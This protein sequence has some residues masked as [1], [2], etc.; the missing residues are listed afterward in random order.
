MYLEEIV[1]DIPVNSGLIECRTV[2]SRNHVVSWLK[3]IAGF[4][5]A[6]GGDLYIGVEGGTNRIIGLDREKADAE[7]R[8]LLDQVKHHLSP[9]PE[10]K[11]S[12]F[13]HGI[14]N[15]RIYIIRVRVQESPVK[16]VILTCH[17]V[18]MIFMHRDG[19]TGGATYDEIDAMCIRSHNTPFDVL[20]SDVKYDPSRFSRLRAFYEENNRSRSLSENDLQAMGFYDA[21]GYLANGALLFADNYK[22]DRTEVLCTIHHSFHRR[23]NDSHAKTRRFTKDVVS[24][25]QGVTT[26]LSQRMN[27]STM[28]FI[29][30]RA[31]LEG[32]ALAVAQRDYFL[33]GSPILVDRFPDRLEITSPGGFY[34]ADQYGE[35]HDLT[36]IVSKKRNELITAVLASCNVMDASG[37]GFVETARKYDAADEKHKPYLRSYSDHFTLVLPDLTYRRGLEDD[38]IPR[39][40]ALPAK[41]GTFRDNAV[42]SFC[43]YR[44]RRVSE[45]ADFLKLRDSH[46]L[47]RSILHN[48][49]KQGYLDK[50]RVSGS[51][52]YKTRREMV[53]VF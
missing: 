17:D 44:A 35:T 52:Y 9:M 12:F 21:D 27:F 11:L 50:D 1:T 15:K 6:G 49:V 30:Q 46:Y 45:I 34:R 3:I 14:L 22:G 20:R 19:S 23:K 16:P 53:E 31:V 29:P 33:N 10:I 32:L 42:L 4:A 51:V 36:G 40:L 47:R 38:L 28:H 24:T 2:L 39:L 18:P 37:T 5:N 7:Y 13:E 26:F 25:I 8:F 48:L 43:Y 41:K